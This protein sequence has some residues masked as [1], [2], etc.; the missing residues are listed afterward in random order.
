MNSSA[1]RV[2]VSAVPR[3]RSASRVFGFWNRSSASPSADSRRSFSST[4]RGS[5]GVPTRNA[6]FTAGSERGSSCAAGRRRADRSAKSVRKGRWTRNESIETASVEG[7]F[8][9]VCRSASGSAEIA[10]KVSAMS[11]NSSACVRAT[12]ATWAAAAPSWTKKLVELGLRSAER[13]LHHRR[14]RAEERAEGRDRAVD[15]LAA[16]GESVAEALGGGLD[17]RPRV[18][19]EG[20]EQVLVLERLGGPLRAGSWRRLPGSPARAGRE[21]DVLQAER[22]ARAHAQGRVDGQRLD[23]LVELQPGHGHRY[24]ACP[25]T[26]TTLGLRSSTTPTRKPPTLTSLPFTSLAPG[27]ALP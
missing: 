17:R 9:I 6:R 13:W 18:A 16:A 4:V 10:A 1:G 14:E 15:R 2:T 27:A 12:G 21:L 25:S 8:S 5:T 22:R 26:S 19:V 20:R 23:L 11:V 24:A 7:V 3:S